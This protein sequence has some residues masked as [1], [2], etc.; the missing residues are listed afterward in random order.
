MACNKEQQQIPQTSETIEDSNENDMNEDTEAVTQPTVQ[1]LI[2]EEAVP[3]LTY[4]AHQTE[5]TESTTLH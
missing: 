1:Q 2:P 5:I 4:V 3:S